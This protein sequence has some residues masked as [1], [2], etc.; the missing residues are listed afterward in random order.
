[1]DEKYKFIKINVDSEI[2]QK[3]ILP[4]EQ[5]IL[6]AQQLRHDITL[7][8]QC[9]DERRVADYGKSYSRLHRN[10]IMCLIFILP[11]T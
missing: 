1:M 6:L 3:I 8:N 2:E 4:A 9:Y 11:S 7:K 10:N 5:K